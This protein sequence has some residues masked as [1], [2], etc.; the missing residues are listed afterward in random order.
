[1]KRMFLAA[2]MVALAGCGPWAE[3]LTEPLRTFHFNAA[4]HN[5]LAD[6][7]WPVV[8]GNVLDTVIPAG[9]AANLEIR[10]ETVGERGGYYGADPYW[11]ACVSFAAHN[12]MVAETSNPVYRVIST[13]VT[14]P[15]TITERSFNDRYSQGGSYCPG[16][17]FSGVASIGVVSVRLERIP[18]E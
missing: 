17:Y 3:K 16:H 1:M 10:V 11:V 13:N 4:Y 2:F 12:I 18:P 5:R 7:I 8:D 15:I 14:V 6:P 9:W